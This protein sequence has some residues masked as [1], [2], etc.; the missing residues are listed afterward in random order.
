VAY[1]KHDY[2]HV[3]K[4]AQARIIVKMLEGNNG[5]AMPQARQRAVPG[6]TPGK[7]DIKEV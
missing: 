1:K 4:M 5:I 6:D 7:T 3:A 2:E